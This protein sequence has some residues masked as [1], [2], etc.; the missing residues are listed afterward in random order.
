MLFKVFYSER[1][2]LA[3]L[4]N[5]SQ[6]SLNSNFHESWV[7][8]NLGQ[9]TKLIFLRTGI[10]AVFSAPDPLST[11][12]NP[13][14]ESLLLGSNPPT[15]S[16]YKPEMLRPAPPLFLVIF[17]GDPNLFL[18]LAF[19]YINCVNGQYQLMI[20]QIY[21]LVIGSFLSLPLK[22]GLASFQVY[23]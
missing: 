10:P 1:T 22:V 11:T 6:K 15:G 16:A 17:L 19:H 18:K 5:W 13:N 23:T 4:E 3:N 12:G 9:Q 8:V 2:K 14:I 7:F 21:V 20:N